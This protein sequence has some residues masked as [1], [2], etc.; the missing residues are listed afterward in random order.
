MSGLFLNFYTVEIS[1]LIVDINYLEYENYSTKESFKELQNS[2]SDIK[3]Y[4][5]NDKILI[6]SSNLSIE[7]PNV[8][9]K[10]SLNLNDNAKVVSKIIENAIIDFANN[11]GYKIRKNKYSNTWEIISSR[12]I[13]GNNISGLVVNRIVHFATHFFNK[14]DKLILGFSL[15]TSLKNS[16][17]WSK[18]DFV[19]GGIDIHGLKGDED[20]IFANRQSLKRFLE[21]RGAT[22]VY[23]NIIKTENL[24]S[25]SFLI[26]EKFYEWLDNNKENLTLPYNLKITSIKKRYLPFEDNFIKSETIYKPQRYFYSNR[27][28]TDSLR[29]YDQMVE[30]YQPYS[31]ELYQ[32][33]SINIGVICPLE[34][35]GETEGF[36]RKIETKLKSVFHFNTLDFIFR[37]IN[38]KDI[39]SYKDIIYDV[40]LLKSDVIYVVV[41]EDHKKLSPNLSPYH[42]CKAKLIG[43]G[44]PT[45]DIQIETIRQNLNAPTMGNI[46]LNTYAKLGGTA[47][48]IEKEDKLKDELVVGIGSTISEDGKYILGIA[49]V[50]HNDGRYMTGD[51]SPLSTFSDYAKNLEDHLYKT[52]CPLLDSMG[53]TGEFRLI[54]HLFK[55]ASE[56][57][58]IKAI[59]DLKNRLSNYNFEYA[60]VHLGYGHNFRLYNNDGRSDLSQ[61]TYIQ[62]SSYSSLLHFVKNSDLPLKI[63]LDKR[64]T[65][66]SLFYLSKQIFWF[67]HLS[68]RSY[69]PSKRTVTIM[70]PSL[71]ARMTEELKKVDGWDYDRLKAVSD[72]LWFI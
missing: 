51:C 13:L 55:S 64:S 5:L 33:K 58:E 46:A 24:N 54:F 53:G 40:D 61:G 26:I 22:N 70:Y 62:L 2:Y 3:F 7:L 66:T 15:S 45:Q 57:Y 11:S 44:V 52:L 60:L 68:H 36:V 20:R 18:S 67:S 12:N 21:S 43:N 42:L 27:K 39:E 17:T 63:D 69:I 47:W 38:G 32:N 25:K 28:N 31:L 9:N 1:K 49:Q 19:K 37:T 8:G 16:F 59:N 34:Y 23:D 4:R 35:Q 72:K 56:E 50:F 10:I 14:D 29:Y 65:F 41:N 30:R 71:M 6:L 48:T